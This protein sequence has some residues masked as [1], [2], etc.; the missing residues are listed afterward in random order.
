MTELLKP[1]NFGEYK[2]KN[3]RGRRGRHVRERVAAMNGRK[4][5]AG[6]KG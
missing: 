6:R 3:I 2:V 4:D 5:P 1:I